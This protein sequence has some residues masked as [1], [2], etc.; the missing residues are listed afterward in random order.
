MKK[1]SNV[2]VSYSRRHPKI[3]GGVNAGVDVALYLT[4]DATAGSFGWHITCTLEITIEEG[5]TLETL[6]SSGSNLIHLSEHYLEFGSIL[7]TIVQSDYRMIFFMI[8]STTLVPDTMYHATS[9]PAYP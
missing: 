6:R 8:A 9:S 4:G 3:R 5:P 1:M 7:P 2:L